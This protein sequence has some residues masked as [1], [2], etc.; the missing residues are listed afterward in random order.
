MTHSMTHM[1]HRPMLFKDNCKVF[2][3]NIF[4]ILLKL[5]TETRESYHFQIH[6]HFQQQGDLS[7]RQLLLPHNIF[8]YQTNVLN[9]FPDLWPECI[10]IDRFTKCNSGLDQITV[11]DVFGQ[12][13]NALV[14]RTVWISIEMVSLQRT[15]H[16]GNGPVFSLI[17][18]FADDGLFYVQSAPY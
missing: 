10:P 17:V 2:R 13:S 8:A 9:N 14:L 3:K 5:V 15:F 12:L 6:H 7:R 11:A 4:I 16:R 1:T 18:D